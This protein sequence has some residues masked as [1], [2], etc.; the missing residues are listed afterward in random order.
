MVAFGGDMQNV[1]FVCRNIALKPFFPTYI[2]LFITASV[3]SLH[4]TNKQA[5]IHQPFTPVQHLLAKKLKL[6]TGKSLNKRNVSSIITFIFLNKIRI[7]YSE[8]TAVYY[9]LEFLVKR[10][11]VWGFLFVFLFL[12]CFQHIQGYIYKL[13]SLFFMCFHTFKSHCF[14]YC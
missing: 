10:F 2:T 6:H 12:F 9:L 13:S 7:F 4:D 11:L 14:K 8:D 3:Y 1:I 5:P